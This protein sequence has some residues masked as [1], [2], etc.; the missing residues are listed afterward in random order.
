MKTSVA[1]KFRSLTPSR[2]LLR[3]KMWWVVDLPALNPFWLDRKCGSTIGWILFRI[4]RLMTLVTMDDNNNLGWLLGKLRSPFSGIGIMSLSPSCVSFSLLI[5][6][7]LAKLITI[8]LASHCFNTSGIMPS[9]SVALFSFIC[10]LTCSYSELVK[11]PALIFNS[12]SSRM[13]LI[14]SF[15]FIIFG[16]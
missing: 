5:R 13:V 2:S 9:G 7:L 6:I 4:I 11:R 1:F 8:L 15:S 14:F 12:F 16:G 10:F 3:A